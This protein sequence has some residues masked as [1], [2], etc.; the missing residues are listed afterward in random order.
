[1]GLS[2]DGG[3]VALRGAGLGFQDASNFAARAEEQQADA[4]AAE[5][6][7]LRDLTM[8]VSLSVGQP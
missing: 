1:L 8:R 2:L 5:A 4:G 7:N 3:Q 6:G